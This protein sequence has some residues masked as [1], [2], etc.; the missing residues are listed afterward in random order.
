MR[1]IRFCAIVLITAVAG[2]VASACWLVPCRR[3]RDRWLAAARAAWARGMLRVFGVRVAAEILDD[4]HAGAAL[5]V[6]NHTGYL[7]IFVLMAVAPAV[8]ISRTEVLRW[9]LLGQAVAAAGTLFVDRV[10]RLSIGRMVA[11]VRKELCSGRSVAFFP[12]ATSSDGTGLLPFKTSLFAA[13]VGEE[14]ETFPVRPFVLS[15][16]SVGGEPIGDSNRKR[17]FWYGD[18]TLIPHVWHLLAE[19]GIDVVIKELPARKMAGSRREFALDLR[20]EMQ[21]EFQALTSGS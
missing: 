21:R 17:V 12:E 3:I 11:K 7:D 16:R 20:E 9:P 2:L 8:F 14:G 19:P 10:N 1:P 13:A 4:G 18:E 5:C 15:Y 6:A